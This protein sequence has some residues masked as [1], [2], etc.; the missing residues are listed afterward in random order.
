M[1]LWCA[2]ASGEVKARNRAALYNLSQQLQKTARKV[3][4][5][6]HAPGAEVQ[7]NGTPASDP[8]TVKAAA[9]PATP[10]PSGAAAAALSSRKAAKRVRRARRLT[11][12]AAGPHNTEQ[13]RASKMQS[14]SIAG[15]FNRLQQFSADEPRVFVAPCRPAGWHG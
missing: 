15:R 8:V 11:R 6:K 5:V 13:H 14:R 1:G 10:S 4:S 3:A 12:C 2:G 9:A 7:L